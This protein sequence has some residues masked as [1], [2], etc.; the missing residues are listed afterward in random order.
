LAYLG[1][2]PG[3]AY[4]VNTAGLAYGGRDESQLLGTS[5][6]RFRAGGKDESQLAATVS[7]KSVKRGLSRAR[8]CTRS[9]CG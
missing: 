5:V 4:L 3:L 1:N 6:Y 2:T 8:H 9:P 7:V